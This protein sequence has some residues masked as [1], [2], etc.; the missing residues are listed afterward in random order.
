MK[1]LKVIEPNRFEFEEKEMPI[2]AYDEALLKMIYCGICGSDIKIFTGQH[3]YAN[4]PKVMGHEISAL[5]LKIGEKEINPPLSVSVNPYFICGRCYVCQSGKKNC[6][7]RS[8]TM[9]VQ[10]DGA[11]SEYIVVPEKQLIYDK[12]NLG[13]KLLALTEPFGVAL[14]AIKRTNIQKNDRIIIFGAGPIGIFCLLALKNLQIQVDICDPHNEKISIAMSL[15]ANDY[16]NPKTSDMDGFLKASTWGIGY[17]ICIEASGSKEAIYN[18]FKFVKTGGKIILIGHNKEEIIMPHSDIIK[19]EL[20]IFASRNSL[21][22][23]NAQEE[24]KKSSINIEKSITD[25]ISFEK[26]PEFYKRLVSKDGK[27]VKALI[28]F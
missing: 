14:H 18:C 17:D 8:Q 1:V 21:N 23:T 20:T 25:I 6:C 10:R 28:E 15:G 4:Y 13:A 24:M 26:V 27:I 7:L 3:P 11:Y 19:K 22:L 12:F 2:P 16:V 9:G 5:L